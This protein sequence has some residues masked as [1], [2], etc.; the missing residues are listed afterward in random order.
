MDT[1]I[2]E[3]ISLALVALRNEGYMESTINEYQ[4]LF[5]RFQAFAERRCESKYTVGLGDSFRHETKGTRSHLFC[6]HVQQQRNRCAELFNRYLEH[7]RI[8]LSITKKRPTAQPSSERFRQLFDEYLRFLKDDGKKKNTI[9]SF[10]NVVCQYL[11]HLESTRVMTLTSATKG[12]VYDFVA[13]LRTTWSAGSIRTALSALRSFFSFCE[14][15][16]FIQAIGQMRPIRKRGI[17]PVLSAQEEKNLW[18]TLISSSVITMRDKAFVMLSLLTGMRSC[19]IVALRTSDIDWQ[20]GT[21][22]IIQAKTGNPLSVPLLPALGN[23][24]ADYILHERSKNSGPGLFLRQKAPHVPLSE[25]NHCYH[26]VRQVFSAA[27]IEK[28]DRICGTRLLRHNAA[29]KML[30]ADASVET[31]SALLGHSDP[32]S[33]IIYLSTDEARMRECC[34]PL[35]LM[36]NREGDPK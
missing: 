26:I 12:S 15:E 17:I 35:P 5:R 22:S 25:S 16:S 31:I 14:T 30:E 20:T 8:D 33:T 27:G 18:N 24:I 9:D 1:S 10:R 36:E 29:S 11:L 32:D 3:I 28:D 21:I 2:Q 6:R 7:G 19:D 4:K 13:E 34:L 23:A